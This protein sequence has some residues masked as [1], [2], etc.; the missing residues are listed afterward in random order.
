MYLAHSKL[1]TEV[2]HVALLTYE[3]AHKRSAVDS[4]ELFF[5][6]KA[7]VCRVNFRGASSFETFVNLL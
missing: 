2:K 1:V 3:D 4:K 7:H 6:N 5:L